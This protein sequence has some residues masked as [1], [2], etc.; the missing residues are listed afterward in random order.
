MLAHLALLT[1]FA[2]FLEYCQRLIAD[3]M[4]NAFR[5]AAGC[6]RADA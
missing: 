6:I 4:F 2:E 3:V 1:A 5:I